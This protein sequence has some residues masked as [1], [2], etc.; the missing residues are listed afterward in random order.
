M[1]L[2]TQ[3]I[4][5]DVA[6]GN[7]G[8]STSSAQG[9]SP[10]VQGA[11]LNLSSQ[12]SGMLDKAISEDQRAGGVLGSSLLQYQQQIAAARANK[13]VLASNFAQ[14]LGQLKDRIAQ[15]QFEN[16]QK[17]A[18]S[19]FVGAT[20]QARGQIGLN[21]QVGQTLSDQEAQYINNLRQQNMAI[22]TGRQAELASAQPLLA[23]EFARTA[24]TKGEYGMKSDQGFF[25]KF[26]GAF[27]KD[28]TMHAELDRSKFTGDTELAKMASDFGIDINSGN[29]QNQVN[30][31]MKQ[32]LTMTANSVYD[33]TYDVMFDSGNGP[34]KVS[35][36]TKSMAQTVMDDIFGAL[37]VASVIAI[38]LTGAISIGVDLAGAAAGAAI[39]SIGTAAAEAGAT[40]M[41]D[42]MATEG[43]DLAA[44]E[45]AGV[46][47]SS[48]I[49]DGAET[50]GIQVGMDAEA[51]STNVGKMLGTLFSEQQ[52]Q[53]VSAATMKTAMEAAAKTFTTTVGEAGEEEALK[54]AALNAAQIISKGEMITEM[55]GASAE[56]A[57][58]A[59]AT[60]A[61]AGVEG[62]AQTG[63]QTG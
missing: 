18:T 17:Q 42:I 29:F 61:E 31:A 19:G 24:A 47:M 60:G 62:T 36:Y 56:G 33:R 20:A 58:T 63:A 16:R 1:P 37:N 32:T 12:E 43:V 9:Y 45:M 13:G 52:L 30:D 57:A 21:Q 15:Q 26:A 4:A 27:G 25:G 44:S 54:A 50:A 11:G 38:P 22:A 39:E 6:Q 3:K 53:G 7:Y 8:T 46:S 14:N 48:A 55:A 10:A 23:K 49:L 5:T 40:T 35:E 41:G 59:G 34:Q 2:D 51:M 28:Q